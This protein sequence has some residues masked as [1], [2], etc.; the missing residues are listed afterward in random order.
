M[1]NQIIQERSKNIP[2]ISYHFDTNRFELIGRLIPENPELIFKRIDDWIK[3]HFENNDA[4]SVFI[5]L[6]YINSGSAEY[7]FRIMKQL[8]AY[9]SNGKKIEI[10]WLYEEDDEAILELGEHYRDFIGAPLK[11][12]MVL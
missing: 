12:S 9:N 10:T 8:A 1:K 7:L 3:L 5:Q 11:M 4:L 2:R 6:E